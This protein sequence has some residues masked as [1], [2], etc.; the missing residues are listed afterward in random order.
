MMRDGK[1]FQ[2]ANGV[3]RGLLACMAVVLVCGAAEQAGRAVRRSTPPLIE[4][5]TME[6][7]LE[8][9]DIRTVLMY[10]ADVTGKAVVPAPGLSGEISVRSGGVV[11]TGEVERLLNAALVTN[12]FRVVDDGTCLRVLRADETRLATAEITTPAAGVS[13]RFILHLDDTELRSVVALLAE[14][15]GTTML[16]AAGMSGR[17]TVINPQPV[18]RDEA[19]K[20]LYAVLETHG[21]SVVE[22]GTYAK[23]VRAQDAAGKPIRRHMPRTAPANVKEQ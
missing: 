18:T 13:E 21:Y 6:L 12:G 8:R 22:Y 11:S 17:V 4:P 15:T 5:R 9:A 14:L 16:P 23:V 3:A 20:I 2:F 10:L 1:Q 19:V 7:D